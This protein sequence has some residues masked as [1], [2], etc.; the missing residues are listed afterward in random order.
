MTASSPYPSD[1][2]DACRELI[3]PVLAAW[4]ARRQASALGFG[5]RPEH[6]LRSAMNAIVYVDRAGIAWRYP[7]HDYPPWQTVY[8]HFAAWRDEGVFTE[9]G[10]LLH[11]LR[12]H[13]PPRRDRQHD[14]PSHPRKHTKMARNLKCRISH[15]Q[16]D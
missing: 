2:S 10:G 6:D 14:P 7:P 12:S 16:R 5:R 15:S 4:R 11:R 3:E 8:R 1:L 13:D 9:P